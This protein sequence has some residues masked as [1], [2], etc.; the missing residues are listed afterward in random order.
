MQPGE[1]LFVSP[2]AFD[3]VQELSVRWLLT[4]HTVV[5]EDQLKG[6]VSD[7]YRRSY[8]ELSDAN[9]SEQKNTSY[10]E[11][12]VR[13]EKKENV[14]RP[15][16]SKENVE[17]VFYMKNQYLILQI[18]VSMIQSSHRTLENLKLLY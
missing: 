10:S 2:D 17:T 6:L 3:S 12:E 8:T 13:E 18:L 5:S 1:F 15:N 4:K 14:M 7:E 9:E 16:S 11:K